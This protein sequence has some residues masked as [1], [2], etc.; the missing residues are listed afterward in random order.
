MGCVLG[1]EENGVCAGE[2]GR[3][4]VCWGKRKLWCVLGK[5]EDGC[6]GG[7]TRSRSRFRDG[8]A[9]RVLHVGERA[10]EE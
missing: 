4:R 5:E 10:G 9:G 2:R 8:G 1:K 3:W 7:E 6:V